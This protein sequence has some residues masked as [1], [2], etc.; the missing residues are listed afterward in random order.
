MCDVVIF[1]S[2]MLVTPTPFLLYTLESQSECECWVLGC[3]H[4][5]SQPGHAV[6]CCTATEEAQLAFSLIPAAR[7]SRGCLLPQK[8]LWLCGTLIATLCPPPGEPCSEMGDLHFRNPS[9]CGEGLCFK[10]FKGVLF[11]TGLSFPSLR[12]QTC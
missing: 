6:L 2:L 7:G 1:V 12:R 3:I 8:G 4:E 5:F 9:A 11:H 10:V